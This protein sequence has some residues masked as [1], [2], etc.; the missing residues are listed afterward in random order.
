MKPRRRVPI[1]F[2]LLG[3]IT[4]LVASPLV[5]AQASA[6]VRGTVSGPRGVAIQGASIT[7]E[8][9]GTAA[10]RTTVTDNTGSYQFPQVPPGTYRI[11]A[12]MD[13]FER[14]GFENLQLLVNT[15]MT[16]NVKLQ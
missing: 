2:C 6:S 5:W 12:N 13:G 16:L 15:P 8:N 10:V 14:I 4:F 9:L 11:Q 7:L 3:C 1:W